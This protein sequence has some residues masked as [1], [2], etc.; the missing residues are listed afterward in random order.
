MWLVE[1]I[2]EEEA[3]EMFPPRNG[4]KVDY[5]AQ[6]A[7]GLPEHMLREARDFFRREKPDWGRERVEREAVVS[8]RAF[9]ATDGRPFEPE[10][11]CF[12]AHPEEPEANPEEF[13]PLAMAAKH[14]GVI[15]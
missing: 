6:L 13:T 2:S 7:Q 10:P 3:R 1:K 9:M 8:V 11:A 4:E 15:R 14:N 5:T 12:V